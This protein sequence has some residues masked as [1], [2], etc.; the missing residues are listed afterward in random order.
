MKTK[1]EKKNLMGEIKVHNC[2]VADYCFIY[3]LT[4]CNMEKDVVEYWG[5]WDEKKFRESIK[6][7]NTNI[8]YLDKK[9]IGFVNVSQKRKVAYLN[10]IQIIPAF[11]GKGIGRLIMEFVEKK[12]R[13]SDAKK[14]KLQ[15]FRKKP[16][17]FFYQK[18]GYLAVNTNKYTVIMEKIL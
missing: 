13:K 4:K 2:R 14:I 1:K 17:V 18:L 12:L 7:E 6:K 8:I 10:N 11:Q 15:V 9:R 3:K 5:N 16:A